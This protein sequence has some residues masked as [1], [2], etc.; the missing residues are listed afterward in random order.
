MTSEDRS[1]RTT[2][3][4]TPPL[5]PSLH[6]PDGSQASSVFPHNTTAAG[7]STPAPASY[8][9]TFTCD[10][11]D[12]DSDFSNDESGL[13][14]PPTTA[15]TFTCNHIYIDSGSDSGASDQQ[16]TA[17]PIAAPA[18]RRPAEHRVILGSRYVLGKRNEPAARPNFD[19][20]GSSDKENPFPKRARLDVDRSNSLL[21]FTKPKV[22]R[23]SDFRIE[24]DKSKR[25]PLFPQGTA[26]QR[27]P[28]HRL[29]ARKNDYV[30]LS[31]TSPLP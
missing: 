10:Y 28:P 5:K 26:P 15:F 20:Y 4:L 23:N 6:L 24:L 29:L 9:N 27:P 12:S 19:I 17:A 30:N 25:K 13:A 31:R 14:V 1:V 11:S 2:D 16:D 7:P 18:P 21:P 8:P 22:R 3:A